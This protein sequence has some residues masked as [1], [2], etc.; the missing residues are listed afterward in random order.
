MTKGA[1]FFFLPSFPSFSLPSPP[2]P[3]P[4][5]DGVGGMEWDGVGGMEWK[6]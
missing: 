2:L 4:W 6:E 3:T 5:W 1:C